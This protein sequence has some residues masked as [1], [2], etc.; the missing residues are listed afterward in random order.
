MRIQWCFL[1]G[2][3]ASGCKDPPAKAADP[4][5]PTPEARP[6]ATAAPQAPALEP[7][8]NQLAETF[9]AESVDA[10]WAGMVE[11]SIDVVAPELTDVTCK[12]MQCRATLTAA[13]EQELMAATE[14]LQ[15]EDSLRGLDGAK[16]VLLSRSEPQSGKHVMTIYVRFDRQ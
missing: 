8:T 12:Q 4:K 13:S 16:S 1:V 2:I 7:G 11:K 3:A 15:R 5:P 6:A 10:A 9:E 14:K